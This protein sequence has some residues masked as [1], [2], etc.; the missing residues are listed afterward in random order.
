MEQQWTLEKLGGHMYRLHQLWDGTPEMLDWL[1]EKG[2][3]A[4]S[5]GS[6]DYYL[7]FKEDDEHFNFGVSMSE[8][9]QE[10]IC[11]RRFQNDFFHALARNNF[12]VDF[13]KQL[14][15]NGDRIEM[16]LRYIDL[17]GVEHALYQYAA[18]YS[19]SL[20][21]KAQKMHQELD[22]SGFIGWLKENVK[23]RASL[24][25]E[26][27]LRYNIVP[28][29]IFECLNLPYA[30]YD[31]WLCVKENKEAF[32]YWI[33]TN[34]IPMKN[35]AE[36]FNDCLLLPND[37]T[38]K[39]FALYYWFGEEACAC[40]LFS[41]LNSQDVSI[42]VRSFLK[43]TLIDYG[44]SDAEFAK[45]L[46]H[47]YDEYRSING[48]REINFVQQ[49]FESEKFVFPEVDVKKHLAEDIVDDDQ[50]SFIG[51][52]N[53]ER[54]DPEKLAKV[55]RY[56]VE[57]RYITPKELNTTIY[58]FTGKRK[59]QGDSLL[60]TVVW[61]GKINDAL[62]I[63]KEFYGGKYAQM[64]RFFDV[65]DDDKERVRKNYSSYADRPTKGLRV[66]FNENYLYVKKPE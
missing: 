58:R 5:D 8:C 41:M 66:F 44:K 19:K 18:D 31:S 40:H 36:I 43:N 2:F 25:P 48:G 3:A 61:H 28:S 16:L 10:L 13:G 62:Y 42:G 6:D 51:K 14:A 52:I 26:D 27:I 29:K 47:L 4:S 53:N 60:N 63:C 37:E 64:L 35:P 32:Q 21:E 1:K 22:E 55:F 7:D 65:D 56:L 50:T 54:N 23:P 39:M 46:Q 30:F 17:Y 20:A 15:D 12:E 59:P 49:S 9:F 33:T 11:V 38:I 34:E 57:N 24:N 45:Q